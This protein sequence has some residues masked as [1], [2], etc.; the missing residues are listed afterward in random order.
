MPDLL[1]ARDHDLRGDLH[2]DRA[3]CVPDETSATRQASRRRTL[4]LP[5]IFF[6][7]GNSM[8]ALDHASASR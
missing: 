8:N 7:H 5:A 3:G 4:M 2:R 6:S 1:L